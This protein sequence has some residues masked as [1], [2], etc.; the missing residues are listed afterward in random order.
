[1]CMGVCVWVCVCVGVCVCVCVCVWVVRWLFMHMFECNEHLLINKQDM[2]DSS[3]TM[4]AI[5]RCRMFCFPVCY[6]K[7]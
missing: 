2:T 1:V 5:I 7:I 4:L 6:P 3:Q